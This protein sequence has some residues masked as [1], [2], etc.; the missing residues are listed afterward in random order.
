LD[1]YLQYIPEITE[2]FPALV[3]FSKS[4]L[5]AATGNVFVLPARAGDITQEPTV[6]YGD[7]NGAFVRWDYYKEVGSPVPAS[8]DE[9]LD[10]LEA[11]QKLH[12]TTE[13]GKKVYGMAQ[14]VDWGEWGLTE[15]SII[16]KIKGNFAFGQLQSYGLRDLEYYDLY[17]DNNLWFQAANLNWKAN[18]RGLF[19]PESYAQNHDTIV[20]N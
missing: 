15:Y 5:S 18:Q 17:N 14:F 1:N 13:S 16:S 10:M 9:W 3:E 6:S 20:K 19:D 7:H 2:N 12:P 8:I 4:Y 11:I